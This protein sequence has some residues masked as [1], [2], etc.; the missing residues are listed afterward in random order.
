VLSTKVDGVILVV[1]AGANTYGIVQR[2]R[3]M[4]ER[5]GAHLLGV[6]LNGVRVTAGGYLRKNYETYY[7]YHQQPQLPS[8]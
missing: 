2:A 5:V 3:D 1:R 6:V 8:A 4:F 7:E